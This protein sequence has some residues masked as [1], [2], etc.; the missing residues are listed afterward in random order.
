M[1]VDV[2]PEGE[3]A[4]AILLDATDTADAEVSL[5]VLRDGSLF[6]GTTWTRE[7]HGDVSVWAGDDGRQQGYMGIVDGTVVIANDAGI[8]DGI[9]AAS[10]RRRSVARR[11][12][13]LR[14]HDGRG[15]LRPGSAWRSSHPTIS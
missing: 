14:G 9:V 5:R 13:G 4:V 8:F 15:S 12:S 2:R 3:P 6:K 7:D 11:R 10:N 1:A